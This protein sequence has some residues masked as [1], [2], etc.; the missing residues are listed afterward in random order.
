VQGLGIKLADARG[1][2][3]VAGTRARG[4]VLWTDTAP[5][6]VECLVLKAK[7]GATLS[8]VNQWRD[9][10]YGTTMYSLNAAAIDIQSQSDGSVRLLCSDGW[11]TEPDFEDLVVR[12]RVER[13]PSHNSHRSAAI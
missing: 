13:A 8:L 10:K 11:G 9:E 6:D 1:A 2:L 5:R 4:I 3:E 7:R 12:L